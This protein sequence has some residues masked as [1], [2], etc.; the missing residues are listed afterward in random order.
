MTDITVTL[1]QEEARFLV[2]MMEHVPVAGKEAI[3]RVLALEQ[4]FEVAIATTSQPIGMT[5]APEAAPKNGR[6]K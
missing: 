3:Y 1:T 5:V 6:D 4:K 2:G